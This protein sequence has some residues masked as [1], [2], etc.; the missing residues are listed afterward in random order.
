MDTCLDC[1]WVNEFVDPSYA[2]QHAY[3]N[4]HAVEL[5]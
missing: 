1:K 2:Y 5:H 3:Q 4:G